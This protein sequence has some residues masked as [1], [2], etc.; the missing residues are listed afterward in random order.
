[1]KSIYELI[2]NE[3]KEQGYTKEII[4]KIY[5]QLYIKKNIEVEIEQVVDTPRQVITLEGLV[6]AM[7][8]M[9][10]VTGS[11]GEKYVITQETLDK[12]YDKVLNKPNM[13][14]KKKYPVI[15]EKKDTDFVVPN[16]DANG[17][18]LKGKAGGY[19][20]QSMIYAKNIYPVDKEIFEDTYIPYA[21]YLR[22]KYG[23]I[24]EMFEEEIQDLEHIEP[25]V[26][27]KL[28]KSVKEKII[29]LWNKIRR[30]SNHDEF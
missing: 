16:N 10:V 14:I 29:S 2:P 11:R 20:V 23:V 26:F 28:L 8:G 12:T 22:E 3:V 19:L 9:Y 17:G 30:K 21:E 15:A 1:M 27:V 7:I 6:M 13:Y 4:L 18:F 5:S 24:D 25:N